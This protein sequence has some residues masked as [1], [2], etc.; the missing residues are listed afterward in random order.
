MIQQNC[1]C[2]RYILYDRF[3]LKRE[4]I[5]ETFHKIGG[6]KTEAREASRQPNFWRI[7]FCDNKE[8]SDTLY[9]IPAKNT[10]SLESP[11]R[12]T[13]RVDLVSTITV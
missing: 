5:T 9:S 13:V 3:Y 10:L 8:E 1:C 11:H 6:K 4:Q 12:D 2:L 7:N